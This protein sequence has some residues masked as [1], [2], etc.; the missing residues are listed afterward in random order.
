M[1][2]LTVLEFCL[3][4]LILFF[5]GSC[6]RQ[7]SQLGGST[8]KKPANVI[9][10]TYSPTSI[11]LAWDH[12]DGATS[13]TVQLL[14]DKDADM[15]ID[16]YTT[17]T[18]DFYQFNGLQEVRGYYVRVRANVDYNTGDWV[19]IMNNALP[20]RIMPKYGFVADDFK[21]P[22]P[23][24]NIDPI[25]Y[26]NFPEGW[27]NHASTRKGSHGGN[28]PTGRQSDV[29]PSGEWLMSNMY[30]N[31][32]AAIIHKVGNW[33]LMMNTGVAANLEMD[34]D[35]PDGARKFSFIYGAATITN[36]NETALPLNLEL[37]VEYSVDAGKNWTRLG[38][39][40]PVSDLQVQYFKE[41]ELDIK[42]PVRFRIGKNASRAR[43]MIDEIA[44]YY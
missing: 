5:S 40:L 14:G 16:S 20:G 6:K 39:P 11:T 24:P 33:A 12:I 35:L 37:S 30:T 28:G 9:L 21:E 13:Y 1:K 38:D 19:Y 32:A 18:K 41:Y 8:D 34:F 22:D 29:F 7:E 42:G 15:P 23:Q 3:F 26:P 43:P 44:I 25:L 36:A 4:T 17:T 10:W 27:E 2:Q 31:S